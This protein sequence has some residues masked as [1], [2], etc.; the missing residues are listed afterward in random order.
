[1]SGASVSDIEVKDSITSL[2][3]E[4]MHGLSVKDSV[5]TINIGG[6]KG[7]RS[8]ADAA[9]EFRRRIRDLHRNGGREAARQIDDTIAELLQLSKDQEAAGLPSS[10]AIFIALQALGHLRRGRADKMADC[11][12]ESLH[13]DPHCEQAHL[14][15][16]EFAHQQSQRIGEGKNRDDAILTAIRHHRDVWQNGRSGGARNNAGYHLC[17][18]LIELKQFEEA[19]RIKEELLEE[20]TNPAGIEKVKKLIIPSD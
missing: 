6:E 8:V 12:A 11:I 10:A 3:V 19:G 13:K 5:V 16:G 20:M 14:I 1:M 15:A 9:T 17:A 4:E 2:E 18:E 7:P